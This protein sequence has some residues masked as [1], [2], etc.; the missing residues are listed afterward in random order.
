MEKL[1]DIDEVFKLPTGK[2]PFV[3]H[4]RVVGTYNKAPVVRSHSFQKRI[5]RH[6]IW[7]LMRTPGERGAV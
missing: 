7:T 3:S 4:S 5:D 2:R 1:L 6:E